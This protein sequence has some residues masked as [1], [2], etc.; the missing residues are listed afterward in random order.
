MLGHRVRSR[1][2]ER[3]IVH[4]S[5]WANS[6][7]RSA[8]EECSLVRALGY[9]CTYC[10]ISD[11]VGHKTHRYQIDRIELP[12]GTSHARLVT[13]ACAN[14]KGSHDQVRRAAITERKA[15]LS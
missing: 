3:H 11:D 1:L 4:P 12:L 8:S 6:P 2:L 9:A 7:H 15:A 14:D 5:P 13:N 10:R